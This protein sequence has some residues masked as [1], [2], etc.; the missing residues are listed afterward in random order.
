M[1]WYM[2]FFKMLYALV[3]SGK[4]ED[5]NDIIKEPAI[6]TIKKIN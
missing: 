1:Y 4:K 5:I 6:K 3:K 2:L